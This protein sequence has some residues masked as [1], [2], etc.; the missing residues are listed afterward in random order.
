MFFKCTQQFFLSL[1]VI[2]IL[3]F[4]DLLFTLML[5]YSL[6]QIIMTHEYKKQDNSYIICL[7]INSVNSQ[8]IHVF[9]TR[10]IVCYQRLLIHSNILYMYAILI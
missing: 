5:K 4:T 6:H 3:S 10:Y 2:S 8:L 7:R 1:I 9:L